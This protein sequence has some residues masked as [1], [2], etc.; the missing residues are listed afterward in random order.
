MNDFNS[1][2]IAEFRA[3]PRA[4]AEAGTEVIDVVARVADPGERERIWARKKE[5]APRYAEYEKKTDRQ[6]PVVLL[7]RA[8]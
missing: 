2:I 4:R 6:I 7:G 5:R 3:S 1:N 8:G